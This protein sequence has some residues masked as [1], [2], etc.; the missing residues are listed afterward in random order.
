MTLLPAGY[1][2]FEAYRFGVPR[3]TLARMGFNLGVETLFGAVP[4]LGDV[5]DATFRAN[6]RN[7]Y[8][9]EQHIGQLGVAPL[10]RPS[11]RG[12]ASFLAILLLL[13]VTAVAFTLWVGLWLFRQFLNLF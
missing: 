3:W 2:V 9:L 6:N 1:I 7:L 11:N 12:I 4:V 5:F 13:G 8:L 10:V